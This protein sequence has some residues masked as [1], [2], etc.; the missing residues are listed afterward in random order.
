MASGGA[1]ERSW[2]YLVFLAHRGAKQ[3]KPRAVR[4]CQR[5][6]RE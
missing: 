2:L 6:L 3:H 1:M 4:S 5:L